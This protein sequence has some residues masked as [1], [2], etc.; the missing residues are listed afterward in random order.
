MEDRTR[1]T[2]HS[3]FGGGVGSDRTR[4]DGTPRPLTTGEQT[5]DARRAG[6]HDEPMPKGAEPGKRIV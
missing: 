4:Q 2:G 5:T 1:R 3:E 6:S